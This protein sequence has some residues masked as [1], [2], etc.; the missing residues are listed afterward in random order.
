MF[1]VTWFP[2]CTTDCRFPQISLASAHYSPVPSLLTSPVSVL[3]S[4]PFQSSL[5]PLSRCLI[6]LLTF[7]QACSPVGSV[8]L[9]HST[10]GVPFVFAKLHPGFRVR[11]LDRLDH[12]IA[13]GGRSQ[14]LVFIMLLF[15]LLFKVTLFT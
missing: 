5:F 15:R 3:Q 14:V 7:I 4:S 2:S 12:C 6:C 10:V 13:T 9:V 11:N 8:V 1:R